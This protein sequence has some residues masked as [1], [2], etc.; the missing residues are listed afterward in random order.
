MELNVINREINVEH[1]R[2]IGI[3]S[4]S[5]FLIGDADTIQQASTFDTPTESLIIGPFTP[6]VPR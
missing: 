6:F 3:S 4:S 2:V 5:L 1:I